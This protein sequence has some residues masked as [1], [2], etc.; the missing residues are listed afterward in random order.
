[1]KKIIFI[2][3]ATYILYSCGIKPKIID[4]YNYRIVKIDSIENTYLIYAE[5]VNVKI[6]NTSIIKI[7][8][9]K[10]ETK[11]KRKNLI[12]VDK[13]Y[14]LDIYSLSPENLVSHNIRGITYNGTL[15]PFDKDYNIKKD[16]FIAKNLNGLCYK[17]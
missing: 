7:V 13:N 9:A 4:G 3:I 2:L 17:E 12:I 15:I 16:L 11:C 14:K 8:S 1:M 6:K 5:K 10:V